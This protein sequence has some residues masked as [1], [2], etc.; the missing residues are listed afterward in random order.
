MEDGAEQVLCARSLA[1][2]PAVGRS[3]FK[4][5]WRALGDD[6]PVLVPEGLQLF[7]LLLL[8][9]NIQLLLELLTQ[10][11]YDPLA[12]LPEAHVLQPVVIFVRVRICV[13]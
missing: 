5:G 8:P 3:G 7:L 2:A 13:F 10:S 4:F 11:M 9:A 12:L 1:R 6:L